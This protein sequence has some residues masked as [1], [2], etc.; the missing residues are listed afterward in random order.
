[1]AMKSL[2]YQGP[3]EDSPQDHRKFLRERFSK[4]KGECLVDYEFMEL[5]LFLV[6]PRGNVQPLAKALLK[7]FGSISAIL[8]ADDTLL[9]EVPGVGPGTL[10][11]FR[12][13]QA[14]MSR[15]LYEEIVDRPVLASWQSL[16]DYCQVTMAHEPREILRVLFLDCKNHLIADEIQQVGTVN[17]TPICPRQVMKRTLEFSASALILVHNHPSGDPTPSR[18][19]IDMTFKIQQAS[20]L[21]GIEL[22]DHVIIGK[23]RNTSFKSMG[24]L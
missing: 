7:K 4:T 12:L 20:Q 11:A 9:L 23:G 19:D 16:M 13:L 24:L 2:L 1:M 8:K 17:L 21:M 3:E 22:H 14:L 6:I 15:V 5:L 10:H 18:G